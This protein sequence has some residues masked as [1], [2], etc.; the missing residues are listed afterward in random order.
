VESRPFFVWSVGNVR[1][2]DQNWTRIEAVDGW[3]LFELWRPDAVYVFQGRTLRWCIAELAARV[4]HF[5]VEFDGATEWDMTVEYLAVMAQAGDWHHR[6]QI[7]AWDRW[8]PLDQATVAFDLQVNGYSMLMQSL[9]L[10]GG[11]A[12]WG[13]GDS[14]E[15]LY[16]LIPKLQGESPDAVHVFGQGEIIEGEYRKGL[17]W[18]TRV[19]ATGHGVAYE[20]QDQANSLAAGIEFLQLLQAENWT[21]AVQ[22]QVAVESALDD[23][24]ARAYGG[25]V[26]VRPNAG[27][28]LFDV[29]YLND[30]RAGGGFHNAKRRVNSLLTEYDLLRRVW[31]QR[32]GFEAV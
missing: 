25:Q 8:V 14:R 23:A 5:Q 24:D 3:R 4:G 22:C 19:R 20:A 28:E 32:V 2:Q 15:V 10:V 9:G 12:Q 30:S 17:A 31:E 11:V 27:L 16:C 21:T 26:T 29:V 7:R 13:H 18:P 1:S 6:L